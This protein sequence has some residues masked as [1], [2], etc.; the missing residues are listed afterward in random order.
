MHR[1]C[2]EPSSATLDLCGTTAARFSSTKG[3]IMRRKIA[4]VDLIL[5]SIVLVGTSHFTT[6]TAA[7]DATA[8]TGVH[9][10]VGTW[11]VDTLVAS[12]NDSPEIAI[13]TPDGRLAG[14]GA[15]RVAGGTWEAVDD[16]TAMLTLVTVFDRAEGAG[17]AVIRG[18]HVVDASGDAWTCECTVTIVGADGTVQQALHTQATGKRIPIEGPEL[19]GKPL[20]VMPAWVSPFAATPT[21]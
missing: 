7:Q 5:A 17:Y 10:F 9:P 1:V 4:G 15:N 16:H 2:A 18:P 11:V 13:V 19:I 8:T 3:A 20:S 6:P 14:L 21:P 12:E